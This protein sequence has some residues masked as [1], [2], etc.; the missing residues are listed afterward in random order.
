LS[1]GT[2]QSDKQRTERKVSGY[3]IQRKITILS[4]EITC[5]NI[6]CR[7]LINGINEKVIKSDNNT[8]VIGKYVDSVNQFVN[9]H[10]GTSV[11]IFT[12]G[13][14]F[15]GPVGSGACSA[16]LYPLLV[17]EVVR[18]SAKVVGKKVCSLQ[19]EI[20]GIILG[21]EMAISYFS[22]GQSK[23]DSGRIYV[24]CD[25]DC[26]IEA[27][28]RK[29]D[30]LQFSDIYKRLTEVQSQLKTMAKYVSLVHIER[31]SGII[32][33]K[34]ADEKAQNLAHSIAVRNV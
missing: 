15:K 19:C 21:M 20:Q 14:V 30:S 3:N 17:S 34:L 27:V 25:C 28:E 31:H 29:T 24:F 1:N 5:D 26:A 22:A 11:M 4:T 12:D 13:S 33:N 7:S 10:K 2:H 32:G 16:V 6:I 18:S 23:N 9:Q 8:E